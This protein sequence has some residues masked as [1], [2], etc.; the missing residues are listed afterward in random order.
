MPLFHRQSRHRRRTIRKLEKNG[1]YL[2][3][4]GYAR[5]SNTNELVSRYVASNYVAGRKLLPNEVVHHKNRNKLDNRQSNL[6]VLTHDQHK[7]RHPNPFLKRL[8]TGKK[9]KF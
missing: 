7:T 3:S 5:F 1:Q 6:E 2:D 4:R 9:Y 8:L